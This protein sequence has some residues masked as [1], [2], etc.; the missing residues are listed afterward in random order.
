MNYG[1]F[2][3]LKLIGSLG[4]FLFG[5]KLMSEALQKV[6]GTKMRQILSAMTSNRV[7][8]VITGILIT[9]I[10]QSSSATTV[11]VV[12]FVNAGLLNLIE[13]IGV[14][15][16]ANVGTTATA[17]LISILG[18]K[19]SMAEIS[20]PMIGLCLP[21]LFSTKRARKNWG[22]LIIGFGLLFIGLEFLKGSMPD[23]Q[24]NPE[25]F[26][27]LREYTDMGYPSYFL[28]LL[29]GSVLTILIQSSSATMALTLVMCANGWIS[30]EI[31]AS[32]VL[33][34]NIGTTV[35]AN[36]AA[37][38]ANTTAKRAALAHFVFN[39]FGVIWVLAIFPFFLDW[40]EHL[41]VFLGIGNPATHTDAVPMALSLFHTVFN[42]S[43][44]LLLIWFTKFI[45]RV[46]SKLIP[47]REN[48]A[49]AF[50]LKHIK[51]GLLSTPDA[52]LF[53]AK[54]E[55]TLYAQNTLDM[56]HRVT[57]CLD[58]PAKEFAKPFEQLVK[59]EDES[60]K[61][62]VEIANYLTKVSES[63]LSTENSQRIRAMFRIVS[64]IE[65]VADSSLNVAKAINRRNEQKV[66]FP[67]EL[68][69]KLKHMF[70]L[71]EDTLN[72]MCRNLAM[73][74]KEVN[75]KKAYETEQAINAYRTVLKQEHLIAIEEKRYDYPT[76]ILYNDI[77]SECEKIGDYAI[78]VTQAIKEIGH[79]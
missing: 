68:T 65:S 66:V 78:N 3:F 32:M 20:L 76:G 41:C 43:N 58:M 53:Q 47:M 50:T 9:A 38:V 48:H 39:F 24:N 45:A 60:D 16:G 28:F 4:V 72:T 54:E 22:E 29:I 15:M 40:I 31:A 5:M 75:A 8:G 46:V 12:S 79:Q 23:L 21:L 64:E 74:Y 18:F 42:I 57:E 34:E 67:E 6:A 77:F 17:W 1:L 7:K 61:I 55:I 14:I 69:R 70:A 52:S 19:I 59:L 26:A 2:D 73:E 33:G 44:V 36:L 56:F 51:I 10:I 37:M 49:D 25:I 71:V 27:F 13:S 62:E 11:M 30:F 63:K 35:T